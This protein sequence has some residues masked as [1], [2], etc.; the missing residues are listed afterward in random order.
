MFITWSIQ[1]SFLLSPLLN[2]PFVPSFMFTFKFDV[3]F[4]GC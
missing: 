1:L 2:R 3:K 4:T